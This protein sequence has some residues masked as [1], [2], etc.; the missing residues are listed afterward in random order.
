[1]QTECYSFFLNTKSNLLINLIMKKNYILLIAAIMTVTAMSAYEYKLV[2]IKS[3]YTPEYFKYIYDELNGRLD[4]AEHYSELDGWVY[5]CTTKYVYDADGNEILEKGYQKFM[6]DDFYTYSTQIHYTY[7]EQGRL[8]SRTNYNLGF[9]HADFELGGVY[10]YVYEGD[11][12]VQRNSYWDE[13][14]TDKFE[15]INYTYDEQGRLLEEAAYSAFFGGDFT[16][17]NGTQ[18]IYDSQNRVTEK[19]QLS[20]DF[21]TGEKT[22]VGGEVFTYDEA[23]NLVE[24]MTYGDS[25]DNP[26]GRE[27]YTHDMSIATAE[28]LFPVENEWDGTAYLNSKNALLGSV[29]YSADWYTGELGVYDE[30]EMEYSPVTGTG[31]SSLYVKP[32]ETMQVVYDSEKARLTGVPAGEPVRVYSPSG[33]M[34]RSN[35]YNPQ[36]G[37]DISNLPSGTY[38]ISAKQGSV[39]IFKK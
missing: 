1:M 10:E 25:K 15:E 3:K 18:Y 4:S 16:Y 30:L 33:L 6:G 36:E 21:Y 23:G 37:L 38:I 26:S 12:L 34:M 20:A 39:K 29:I 9:D 35:A 27:V 31:I 7:D 13:E 32:G 24:W 11:R 5:D 22:Q 17:S 8:T 2:S 14:R 19:I 28:T